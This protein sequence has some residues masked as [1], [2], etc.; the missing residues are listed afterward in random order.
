MARIDL[1]SRMVGWL[2]VALPLI[3][4]AILSTLFLLADRIDP[5]AAIPYAKVDVKDLVRDPRMT[6]PTYAGTT[7]DGAGITLTATEAR[8]GT[9]DQNAS[10]TSLTA[11]LETPDGQRIDIAAS[12]AVFD[13]SGKELSLSDGVSLT[14]ASGYRVDTD[15][16]TAR[17]D[18]TRVQSTAPVQ[19]TA[20]FGDLSA[21]AFTLTQDAADP[22]AY[23]L[24]FNGGVKLIYQPQR[25]EP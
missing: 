10:A 3:A 11:L 4:L 1:H 9:D 22:S 5:T 21:D 20:P 16:L 13:S 15:G 23:L 19:V 25:P 8:P 6:G 12:Q 14:T 24:V 7:S 18:Q 17:L 2:K